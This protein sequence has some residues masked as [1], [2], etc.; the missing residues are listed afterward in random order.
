MEEQLSQMEVNLKKD[1]KQGF[2][3]SSIAFLAKFQN[4]QQTPQ[5]PGGA[6]TGGNND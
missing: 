6:S 4:V 5:L 2:E 3:D 1:L